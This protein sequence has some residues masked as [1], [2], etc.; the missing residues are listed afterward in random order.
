MGILTIQ[1]PDY[2]HDK[3]KALAVHKDI[4]VNKLIE[5]LSTD[6]LTEF[7]AETRFRAMADQGNIEEV[8]RV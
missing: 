2:K 7:D 1:I 5:D 4:S 8:K 6:A 3:L